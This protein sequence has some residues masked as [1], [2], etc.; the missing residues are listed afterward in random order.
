MAT[1]IEIK[2]WMSPDVEF[3]RWHPTDLDEVCF[4]LELDI[5]FVEGDSASTF[6]VVVATPEGARSK[7]QVREEILSDR[8]LL[9]VS[10][11]TWAAVRRRI[12]AI[13][14]LCGAGTWSEACLRLQR[15]FRWEY[16]DLKVV[17]WDDED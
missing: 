3:E 5:G 15:F 17:S 14:D 11:F 7:L 1:Q 2:G 6:Y 16:E 10:S 13:V 12:E 9:L 4:L 8:G